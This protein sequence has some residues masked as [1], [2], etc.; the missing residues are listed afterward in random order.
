MDNIIVGPSKNT[1]NVVLDNSLHN[2][3]QDIFIKTQE[4]SSNENSPN[5]RR[6]PDLRMVSDRGFEEDKKS[7]IGLD[8]LMNPKKK[9]HN[10]SSSS[11]TASSYSNKSQP[12]TTDNV[13]F[14]QKN[15]NNDDININNVN[16]DDGYISHHSSHHS[17]HHN[18]YNNG[19]HSN[20]E[21][22]NSAIS[23]E[24]GFTSASRAS[25]RS[26]VSRKSNN[27][28]S[29]WNNDNNNNNNN[30]NDNNQPQEFERPMTHDEILNAKR[31]L[32]YQFDRLDARGI[33]V[34]KKFTISS[35]LDE[36]K[37]EYEKL[38]RERELDNSV[39]FQ[40]KMLMAFI[41]ASEFLNNRFDPFNLKLD[42]WSENVNENVE[43]YDEVMEELHE[44]YKDKGGKVSPELRLLMMVG[45]SGFMFHLTNSMFKSSLPG[46][47]QVMK[48]NPDLAK[49]FAQASANQ[50][51]QKHSS[52]DGGFSGL[53]NN[54]F[55]GMGLGNG[56]GRPRASSQQR[57]PPHPT[58]NHNQMR[59][60]TANVDDIL[61]N[62]DMNNRVETMST[63]SES[64]ITELNDESSINGLLFNNNENQNENISGK[65]A[66]R[67]LNI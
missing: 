49:Q 9:S 36:M 62:M 15:N 47:D 39:K 56:G 51:N 55:S 32:L 65:S 18:G 59:G 28:F 52:D 29:G 17:S 41:T 19:H 58:S 66:R 53:M 7:D 12:M 13:N 50:M 38:K 6:T 37:A 64:E 27:S 24:S 57:P 22:T 31:E 60:P 23:D 10:M 25:R 35:N 34:P 48:Q 63:A 8:L 1:S 46:F 33:R 2:N 44:K 42:G 16:N 3:N 14:F 26:R 30:Y 40:K 61:E 67:T 43:D 5:K 11:S 21:D 54:M 20:F 4:H 45:G